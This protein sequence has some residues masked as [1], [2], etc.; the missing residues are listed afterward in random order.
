[1]RVPYI[2]RAGLCMTQQCLK[3]LFVLV[4]FVDR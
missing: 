1:M 2:C 3:L 4:E